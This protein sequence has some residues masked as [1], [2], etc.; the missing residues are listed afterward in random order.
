VARFRED[1]VEVAYF[2]VCGGGECA[3]DGVEVGGVVLD[4]EPGEM[5]AAGADGVCGDREVGLHEGIEV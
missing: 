4:L 1:G 2:V 3:A 5:L